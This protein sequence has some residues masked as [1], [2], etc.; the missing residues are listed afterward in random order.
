MPSF[1]S[2]YFKSS[3]S[4]ISTVSS[5][6]NHSRSFSILPTDATSTPRAPRPGKP[7]RQ[8]NTRPGKLKISSVNA[9]GFSTKRLSLTELLSTE[10][11]DI[12]LCQE[13]KIDASVFT[14]E[15]FPPG[16]NVYRKDRLVNGGG[17]CIAVR[18]TIDV[19]DCPELDDNLEL[20]W[21]TMKSVNH[22]NMYLGSFCRPSDKDHTYTELLKEPLSN[23]FNKHSKKPPVILLAGDFNYPRV[24]WSCD[25]SASISN[26]QRLPSAPASQWTNASQREHCLDLGSRLLHT[27]SLISSLVIG[28]EFSITA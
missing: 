21:L 2:S 23:I 9:N 5:S 12:L 15:I 25:Y 13:T 16:Y 6:L 17:V 18:D 20:I 27:P 4:S 1:S 14:S 22:E 10:N 8:F 7:P 11:P 3:L 24:D 19:T 28:R 26:S